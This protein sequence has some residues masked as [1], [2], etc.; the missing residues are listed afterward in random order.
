MINVADKNV[1]R[2]VYTVVDGIVPW[3]ARYRGPTDAEISSL[4]GIILQRALLCVS[5]RD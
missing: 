3:E 5:S 4:R 2:E 1:T